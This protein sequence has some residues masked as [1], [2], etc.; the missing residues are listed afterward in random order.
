MRSLELFGGE[1]VALIGKNGSGKTT[2]LHLLLGLLHPDRGVIERRYAERLPRWRRRGAIGYVPQN[3]DLMLQAADVQSEV[4][5]GALHTCRDRRA[6]DRRAHELLERFQLA[7]LAHEPVFSLSAGQRQRVAVAA[8]LATNPEVLL[9]DEP[10]TGQN[11]GHLERL[12]QDTVALLRER[13]AT[14]V[15]ATHDLRTALTHADRVVALHAGRVAFDGAPARIAEA[16]RAAELGLP[17][18]LRVATE[19]HWPLRGGPLAPVLEPHR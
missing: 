14:L 13:G 12:M 7:G 8:A 18:H 3:A 11:R 10:T 9:L 5:F 2:L 15:F 17:T 1:T 6:G 4:A 16:A 19:L